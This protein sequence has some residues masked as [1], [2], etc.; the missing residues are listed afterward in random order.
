MGMQVYDSYG[1]KCNS[2]FLLN[3][4]F[5]VEN[6]YDE[7]GIFHNEIRILLD[8]DIPAAAADATNPGPLDVKA[9]MCYSEK[10]ERLG[11]CGSERSLRLSMNYYHGPADTVEVWSYLRF[12]NADH[13]ELRHLPLLSPSYS[14]SK[15]PISPISIQNEIRCLE[16]LK[17]IML[18]VSLH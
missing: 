8:M 5:A 15:K 9:L 11:G 16:M 17:N 3:Y 6:N 1:R 7:D 4:G 18:K 12:I 10:L 13:S 2:R 14:L